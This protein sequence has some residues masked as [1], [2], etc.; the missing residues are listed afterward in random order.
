[1]TVRIDLL[2]QINAQYPEKKIH[3]L[4]KMNTIWERKKPLQGY[5]V[6]HNLINSF[7]T[8]HKIESLLKAGADLT[9]TQLDLVKIADMKEIEEIMARCGIRYIPNYNDLA[10]EYDIG[11]DCGGRFLN[12][13]NLNFKKGIIELTQ[14]GTV[15]YKKA[16]LTCPVISVDDSYLK[17]LECM[18]GTGEAFI[19]ALSELTHQDFANQSFIVFGFGKVGQGIVRYLSQHTQAITVVEKSEFAL[20]LAKKQG[21]KVLSAENY[22]EIS[23]AVRSSYCVVTATGV[24]RLLAQYLSA[25]DVK[26]VYVANMGVDD[27]LGKELSECPKTLFE[28]KPVNFSLRHPTRMKYLDPIFY[29][30]NLAA[31]FL[32]DPNKNLE[33]YHPFDSKTDREIIQEWIEVHGEPVDDIWITPTGRIIE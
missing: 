12:N 10:G 2:S 6:L 3:F 9:V 4:H 7:E 8:L 30:H 11:M 21:W 24:S 20:Q 22:A 25:E 29:A 5:R 15:R 18:F 17:N 16:K 28:G 19:R 26:N 14:V 13:P 23:S 27:E 31:E 33:G 32:L 1:M